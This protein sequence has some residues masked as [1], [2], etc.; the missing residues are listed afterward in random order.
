MR[1]E[2]T[3]SGVGILP[4]HLPRLTGRFYRVDAGRSREA[5]GTGPG[6]SIVKHLLEQYGSNLDISSEPGE[7]ASFGF[8]LPREF[9]CQDSEPGKQAATGQG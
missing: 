6:L 5:G 4:Q 8:T 9:V 3:D 2:V 1:F 7:G